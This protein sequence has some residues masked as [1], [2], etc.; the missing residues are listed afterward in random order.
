MKRI[1]VNPCLK[2]TIIFVKTA[3]ETKREV[4]ELIITLSPGGGNPLHYHTSY[5]ET[6]TPLQGALGL[7]LK[8]KKQVILQPGK[9]HLVKKGEVHRFFNPGDQEIRFRNEVSPGHTGFENTL[10]ILAALASDG[11]YST[12]NVPKSFTHLAICGMM[13]DMRLPGLMSLTLP[14]LKLMAIRAKKK[15]IEQQL[16]D[17]YCS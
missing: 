3:A 1:I 16:L 15:G 13:S 12:K 6:F 10:R 7:E 2:E 9:S 5:S 17:K 8:N 4:T 11:L 14:L